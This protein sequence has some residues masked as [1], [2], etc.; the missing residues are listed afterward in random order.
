LQSVEVLAG[1]IR[2]SDD[3]FIEVSEDSKQIRRSPSHPLPAESQFEKRAIYVKG[4]NLKGT[5]IDSVEKYFA[6]KGY[7]VRE[8]RV[9]GGNASFFAWQWSLVAR[10]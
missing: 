4:W 3:D 2:D 6:D 1:V 10:L 7:K 8:W 5:T 9:R